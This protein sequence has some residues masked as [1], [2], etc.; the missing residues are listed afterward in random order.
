MAPFEEFSD[1]RLVALYDLIDPVRTD[2]P[3]YVGLAAGLDV[4]S[5]IDVGCGTGVI[6]C[7][8][9]RL[10]YRVTGVDPAPAMLDIARTRLGG[11]LVRWIE[12]DAVSIDGPPADLAMMTAHVAQVISDDDTWRQT[13]AATY[14]ALRLGGHLVFDSRNPRVEAWRAWKPEPSRTR[15]ED[16]PWGPVDVWFQ[17]AEA[18]GDLVQYEI[19]YRFV[20]S[21][22]E[23]VSAN[24]LR[25]RTEAELTQALAAEGFEVRE[26]FG[27]W[28]RNPLTETSP[29]MIFVATRD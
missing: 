23:L 12:G 2:T 8:L 14:R 21:G 22:E 7:E 13:L 27:D 20:H 6:A 29:E 1:P 4:S 9:A 28:D 19:H 15:V 11:H 25:F 3:F 18:R 10:G 16:T 26:V 24:V 17:S 5:I